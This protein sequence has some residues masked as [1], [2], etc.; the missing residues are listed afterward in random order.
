[1]SDRQPVRGA[2]LEIA[3]VEHVGIELRIERILILKRNATRDR[4]EF[5]TPAEYSEGQQV[6]TALRDFVALYPQELYW[7]LI[8]KHERKLMGNGCSS[9]HYE[10]FQWIA[11]SVDST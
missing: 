8:H 6:A 11:L 1:M 7:K 4:L 5:T 10:S 2:L 9:S 3:R